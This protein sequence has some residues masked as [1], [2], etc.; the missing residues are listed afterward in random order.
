MRIKKAGHNRRLSKIDK[1]SVDQHCRFSV[2]RTTL[3]LSV[4]VVEFKSVIDKVA[5]SPKSIRGLVGFTV[6]L[7]GLV[8]K[9]EVEQR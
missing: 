7:S 4:I 9:Q 6:L 1:E 2:G 5:L 8:R 3:A